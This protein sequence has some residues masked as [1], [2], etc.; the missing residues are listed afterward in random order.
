MCAA[1]SGVAGSLAPSLRTVGGVGL[2]PCPGPKP[3]GLAGGDRRSALV[4]L[5]SPNEACCAYCACC[6]L[7]DADGPRLPHA[8]QASKPPCP[9]ALATS[10]HGHCRVL[11]GQALP[12]IRLNYSPSAPPASRLG[13][14]GRL[15]SGRSAGVPQAFR[16]LGVPAT[17]RSAGLLYIPL[18]GGLALFFTPRL[19]A[20][21]ADG[22]IKNNEEKM[23]KSEPTLPRPGRAGRVEAEGPRACRGAMGY[24]SAARAPG[25]QPAAL[26][27]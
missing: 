7:I 9:L 4:S 27:A 23:R 14:P 26:P 1:D 25:S 6:L 11:P 16:G 12:G 8:P 19:E 22:H 2:E 21:R 10:R 15:F 18:P 13:L 5:L 20:Q 17:G 24:R 3:Y